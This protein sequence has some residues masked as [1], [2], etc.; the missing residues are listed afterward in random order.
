MEF[1]GQALNR[2][3]QNHL[4]KE[5]FFIS[6]PTLGNTLIL[7]QSSCICLGRNHLK[8]TSL[9]SNNI[10][11]NLKFTKFVLRPQTNAIDLCK[12][13]IKQRIPKNNLKQ[14]I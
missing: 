5:L 10:I 14:S 13:N 6:Q 1:A 9:F 12:T 3:R 2:L 8:Y 4:P 11:I 7:P